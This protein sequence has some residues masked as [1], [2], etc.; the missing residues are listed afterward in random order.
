MF[1]PT[2]AQGPPG[3]LANLSGLT[4]SPAVLT[5]FTQCSSASDS[6]S[7]T[8]ASVIARRPLSPTTNVLPSDAAAGSAADAL[9]TA[10]LPYPPSSVARQQS[11]VLS[12]RASVSVIASAPRLPVSI[13]ETLVSQA[14]GNESGESKQLLGRPSVVETL[15][16]SEMDPPFKVIQ[17]PNTATD[18]KIKIETRPT[19][20]A[21]AEKPRLTESSSGIK[22]E[23]D[24]DQIAD[25]MNTRFEITQ[26]TSA[27]TLHLQN[28]TVPGAEIQRSL[29]LDGMQT[30][31][32]R[33]PAGQSMLESRLTGTGSYNPTSS[34]QPSSFTPGSI[35]AQQRPMTVRSLS[36]PSPRASDT[37]TQS[38]QSLL[39]S[40]SQSFLTGQNATKTTTPSVRYQVSEVSSSFAHS[41]P[42][43]GFIQ[44]YSK[45]NIKQEEVHK[46]VSQ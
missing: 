44:T 40:S 43:Q 14:N 4:R 21:M 28:R 5:T 15:S 32:Y 8:V 29:S 25:R 10:R 12:T 24:E 18:D 16:R 1:S 13:C 38:Q 20:F 31:S 33:S 2:S 7:S 36:V 34:P 39:Y 19:V 11:C 3:S 9:S 41:S 27:E 46:Q 37:V 22:K 6:S 23:I 30:E 35:Y 26:T 17:A 45:A 42:Q